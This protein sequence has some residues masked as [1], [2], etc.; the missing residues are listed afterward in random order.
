M[1]MFFFLGGGTCQR[2]KCPMAPVLYL[3]VPSIH[4]AMSF[5]IEL[6]EL[7]FSAFVT[8]AINVAMMLF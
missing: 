1:A 6:S 2:C 8:A 3:L 4:H 5:C 7:N